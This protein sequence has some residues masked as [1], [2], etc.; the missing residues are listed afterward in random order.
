MKAKEREAGGYP[1][2]S[3]RLAVSV[4]RD[5]WI[6]Q[7]DAADRLHVS[8]PRIGLLV[9]S[10]VLQAAH[11]PDGRAGVTARSVDTEAA[12]RE[13]AGALRRTWRALKE[14]LHFI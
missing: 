9:A 14:I 10:G 13:S 2:R 6:S 1:G 7:F 4:Q 5:D 3:S 12:W 8:M 11:D